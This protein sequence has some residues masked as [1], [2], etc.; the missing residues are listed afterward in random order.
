MTRRPRR[1]HSPAFKA[2][3]PVAAIKGG[4]TLHVKIGEL[5]LENDFLSGPRRT[6]RSAPPVRANRAG[7]CCRAQEDD[8]SHREAQR[9]PSGHRAGD[10]QGQRLLQAAPRVGRRSEAYAPHRQTAHGGPVRGQPNAAGIAGPG[11]LQGRAAACLDADETHGDRSPLPAAKHL[12]TGAGTQD[13]PLSAA[14]ASHHPAQPGLGDGHH[15]HPHGARVHLPCGRAGLVHPEGPA[16]RVSITLEADFCVEAVEEA[17]ARHGAPEIFNTDQG[18]QGGLKRSSQHLDEG[19]CD[20]DGKAALEPVDTEG[21][22]LTRPPACGAA[23]AAPR[24]SA[25]G[26]RTWPWSQR[27][28]VMRRGS[29]PRSAARRRS[30]SRHRPD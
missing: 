17:L 18:S 8:R 16:W 9:Q 26:M 24:T 21:P 28:G 6:A 20:D 25:S 15:L 19:G 23:R 22:A 12:E 14:K 4:K 27:G 10:Q 29:R 2:K 7:V 30:R 11:G 13:L 5:T 1:N 3:V